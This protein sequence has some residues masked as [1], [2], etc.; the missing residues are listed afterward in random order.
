[1]QVQLTRGSREFRWYWKLFRAQY[2]R[3]SQHWTVIAYVVIII[4]LI[5]RINLHPDP[6]LRM[7]GVPVSKTLP[8]PGLVPDGGYYGIDVRFVLFNSWYGQFNNQIQ[9]LMNA[10]SIA[11][12]LDA[13]LVLPCEKLGK[14]SIRDSRNIKMR[15]LFSTRELVGA[16][17]NYS[18]LVSAVH[19][20]RPSEFLA[21][22]DGRELLNRKQIVVGAKS[23][24]YYRFLFTGRKRGYDPGEP[25]VRVLDPESTKPRL[26][27]FCDFRA[28]KALTHIQKLH[29]RDRFVLLPVTFR[30]HDINCSYIDPHWISLRRYLRPRNEFLVAVNSFITTLQHP[31][32]AVH[33]RFFINGDLGQFTPRSVVNMLYEQFGNQIDKANTIFLAYTPSSTESVQIYN[34]LKNE[35]HG[36]VVG[37]QMISQFLPPHAKNITELP[38]HSVLMDMW[39]CVKSDM[40]LGRLGSSMSWNVVYWRQVLAPDYALH[41]ESVHQPLWYALSNFT[42][43]GAM[44]Y[45]GE[46]GGYKH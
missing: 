4:L 22:T 33:L 3:L 46:P 32:L 44:R 12:D 16:Y 18:L 41:D 28:S 36:I 25:G 17:F 9:A 1:M 29:R 35:F 43:T 10:I 34:L 11:R 24:G 27:N 40:F 7:S 26:K 20:V 30:H 45:E 21:S 5:S 38:L 39:V 42:T 37:G 14:E 6:P 13:V 8:R 2:A 31:I 15:R 19:A 23:G